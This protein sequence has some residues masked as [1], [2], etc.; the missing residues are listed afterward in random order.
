[1]QSPIFTPHRYPVTVIG[2]RNFFGRRSPLD[3]RQRV[4]NAKSFACK[5]I[6]RVSERIALTKCFVCRQTLAVQ[7][8]IPCPWV[9]WF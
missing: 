9:E 1:H 4:S 2:G 5:K 3:K 8:N 7:Q 6:C